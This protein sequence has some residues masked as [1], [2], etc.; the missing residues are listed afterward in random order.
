MDLQAE[1]EHRRAEIKTDEYSM[2]IGELINLYEDNEIDIHPEFQRYFRW[3][4]FQKTRLIESVLPGIPIPQIFVAQQSSGIWDVVDGVQ[5]LS[6]IF[7]FVGVLRYEDGSFVEPLT[8]EP[9]RYLPS[10]GG[11]V[12]EG[13]SNSLASHQRLSIKRSRLN[14]SIILSDSDPRSKFELFQRLDTGGSPLADQEV[15]NSMLVAANAELYRWIRTLSEDPNFRDC[16]PLSERRMA[17]QYDME[18]VLRFIIFRTLPESDLTST[19]IG[20]LSEFLT[21]H[22]LKLAEDANFDYEEEERAFRWTFQ[23]LSQSTDADTFKKYD[24]QKQRFSG[25]LLVTPFEVIAYGLGYQYGRWTEFD[26]TSIREK[27]MSIWFDNRILQNSGTGV[28]AN[29]RIPVIVPI[30]RDLFKP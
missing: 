8:L 9:T 29:S 18:L 5:R 11:K 17:E 15:R 24:D 21:D 4:T 7:Q 14:I 6:T 26:P 13:D 20:D 27:I 3:D 10:L 1:I 22:M 19:N 16:V 25:Q 2:S 28:R 12:W 30:G 23:I